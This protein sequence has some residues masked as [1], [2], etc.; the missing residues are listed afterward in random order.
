V[1]SVVET[2]LN[3]GIEGNQQTNVLHLKL[4][5]SED[6][7]D[8]NNGEIP[9][10]NETDPK[11]WPI[12]SGIAA[13]ASVAALACMIILF[14]PETE[15]PQSVS[16][17]D[18]VT[19]T[20][21]TALSPKEGVLIQ[22]D[23]LQ[24][25]KANNS[26]CEAEAGEFEVST[27]ID[28]SYEIRVN[29]VSVIINR[30]SKVKISISKAQYPALPEQANER[31]PMNKFKTM[32]GTGIK[33]VILGVA[34]AA[35]SATL[36]AGTFSQEVTSTTPLELFVPGGGEQPPEDGIPEMPNPQD[37]E[38]MFE[39]MF[40]HLDENSDGKL[41]KGEVT[42]EVIKL[43]DANGDGELSSDE[44]KK[45]STISPDKA[46]TMLVPVERMFRDADANDDEKLS[47]SELEMFPKELLVGAD[48]DRDGSLNL[49]E[50]KKLVESM[51]EMAA[52]PGQMPGG[53]APNDD[54]VFETLDSN[55]DGKLSRDELRGSPKA[56][57]EDVEKSLSEF[58]K[59]NDLDGDGSLSRKEFDQSLKNEDTE[60]EDTGDEKD[61]ESEREGSK[62]SDGTEVTPEKNGPEKGS[63]N[64]SEAPDS[65]PDEF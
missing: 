17:N 59:K 28:N 21:N 55:G 19:Q 34:V 9:E 10:S 64:G 31:N 52:A 14:L 49:V 15:P 37:M 18:D 36:Q 32:A 3:T 5:E 13:A 43:L 63:G 22:S 8:V 26:W 60:R 48:K 25:L 39:E 16:D 40:K 6:E 30:N 62:K 4:G 1:D 33:G 56:G 38:K 45:L 11:R 54:S 50:F 24:A 35:G 53:I 2:V 23:T 27:D 44:L 57:P 61:G 51:E 47:G 42:E 7:H 20:D 65:D 12:V 46:P 58:I 29:S 41:K